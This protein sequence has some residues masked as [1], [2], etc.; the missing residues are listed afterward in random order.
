M[1]IVLLFD[2]IY[3]ILLHALIFLYVYN[4]YLLALFQ[5]NA[6]GTIIQYTNGG[7]VHTY[8]YSEKDPCGPAKDHKQTCQDAETAVNN[9]APVS[10]FALSNFSI[11]RASLSEPHVT[12]S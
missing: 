10:I 12:S 9:S 6:Q 11:S 1:N 7:G 8:S 2:A 5:H 4:M 3:S